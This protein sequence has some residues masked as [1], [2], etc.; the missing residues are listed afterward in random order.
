MFNIFFFFENHAVY[1]VM[2]KNIVDPDR[3]QMTIWGMRIACWM[4]KAGTHTHNMQYLLVFHCNNGC[5]NVPQCY[6]TRTSYQNEKCF[7]QKVW[8]KSKYNFMFHFFF[9]FENRAVYEVMWKNIVDPGRP[10][11]TIWRMRIACWM[12]KAGTHTH[13]MQYLLVFHC[14]NG[15]TNVPQCY[16]TR[17][18]PVL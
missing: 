1:E 13:N 3:P 7:R 12:P 16:V 11:M 2:W 17:T 9:F 8:K 15:C 10:Q 6:V 5:T 14:N 18:L 4:P